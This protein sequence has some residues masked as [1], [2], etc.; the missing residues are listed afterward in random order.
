MAET[1][2]QQRPL[3]CARWAQIV[4][5]ALLVMLGARPAAADGPDASEPTWLLAEVGVGP[6]FGTG[7]PEDPVGF[8]VRTQFGFGGGFDDV[9]LRFY[10]LASLQYSEMYA[11]TQSGTLTSDITRR[12]F[13][14][15]A[16]L[17]TMVVL[18]RVRLFF[19]IGIGGSFLGS[20]A[21]VND[22]DRFETD[23]SRFAVYVSGGLTY[24][25]NRLISLGLLVE[26]CVPTAR[27]ESDFVSAVSRVPDDHELLG[28]TSLLF[29]S[30]F[31]F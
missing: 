26:T 20:A 22:R 8:G 25:L 6:V 27:P 30:S 3:R 23:A 21:W 28:W 14:I 9:P 15:A 12:V 24:R 17:R 29:T 11:S 5:V 10:L 19:D 13:D 1:L 7:F 16:H 31:H 18:Q 4:G 2:V